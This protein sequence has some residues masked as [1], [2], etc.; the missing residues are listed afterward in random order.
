M[1]FLAEEA[2]YG[3]AQNNAEG[4][5][6]GVFVDASQMKAQL[7]EIPEHLWFSPTTIRSGWNSLGSSRLP[8]LAAL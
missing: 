3:A 4:K 8:C 1:A 7:Y 5:S 2:D 6:G